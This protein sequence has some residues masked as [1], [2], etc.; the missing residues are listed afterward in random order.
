MR[1]SRRGHRQ[2]D[3]VG[4]LALE[5]CRYLVL[6]S[7]PPWLNQGC[8]IA[9]LATLVSVAVWFRYDRVKD[10]HQ[11]AQGSTGQGPPRSSSRTRRFGF[12]LHCRRAS[13]RRKAPVS[14]GTAAGSHRT[15]WRTDRRGR[16]M[17]RA[18]TPTAAALVLDA[19]TLIA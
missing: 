9:R 16:Q 17:G 18:R 7:T 3:A 8:H 14:S 1:R 5:L 13:G 19:G 6:V 11:F 2:L 4:A 12:G 15:I 10:R